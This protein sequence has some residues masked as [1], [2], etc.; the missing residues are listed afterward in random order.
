MAKTSEQELAK[1]LFL[2]TNKT[3]KEIA[4]IVGVGEK[5]VGTW[6]KD[7]EWVALK[8]S[9]Q[10]RPE[11]IIQNLF[12]ELQEYDDYMKALTLAER[13]AIAPKVN[14]ARAKCVK[15]I[16]LLQRE[17]GL[18][19]IVTVCTRLIDKIAKKDLQLAKS[20]QPY[21]D[22]LLREASKEVR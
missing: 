4:A 15:V 22:E 12:K 9:L 20:M 6:A 7:D 14:D 17:V 11:K 13:I 8:E 21:V 18:T 3:Y 2:E 19:Q 10:V 5:T 16:T 1:T